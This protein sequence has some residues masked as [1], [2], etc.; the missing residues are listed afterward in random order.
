MAVHSGISNKIT[1]GRSPSFSCTGELVSAGT[2][3]EVRWKSGNHSGQVLSQLTGEYNFENI[4]AAICIG[5]YFGVNE[6]MVS[7]AVAEYVPDNSRS[8][9]IRKGS[10]TIILDAYNA[11]PTSVTAALKN[12][13]SFPSS[14]KIIFLGDMAELGDESESEHRQILQQL[15]KIKADEIILVGKNFIGMSA[16]LKGHYFNSSEEAASWAKTQD[17]SNAAVLIKGSRSMKMEKVLE[18]L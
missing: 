17:F 15:R 4:L 2:F 14:H 6:A 18:G 16:L 10:N 11:N 13:D 12:F 3:L 8:Q 5:S 9:L 1:Y 7:E